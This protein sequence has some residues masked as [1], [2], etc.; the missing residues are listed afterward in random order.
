MRS[1]TSDPKTTARPTSAKCQDR[2]WPEAPRDRFVAGDSS[3]GDLGLGSRWCSIHHRRVRAE[4]DSSAPKQ[5]PV[6]YAQGR[7]LQTYVVQTMAAVEE[8][9]DSV[10]TAFERNMPARLAGDL[11]VAVFDADPQR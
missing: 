4:V 9:I 2:H 7:D 3:T 8:V 11:G 6:T 10:L 1:W 5:S